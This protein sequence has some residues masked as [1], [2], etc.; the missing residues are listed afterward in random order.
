VRTFWKRGPRPL[1]N[2]ELFDERA[3]RMSKLLRFNAPREVLG[4]EARLMV[5][6][7]DGGRVRHIWFEICALI[8]RH[9]MYYVVV[10]ISRLLCRFDLYHWGEH[11][12][13][14]A[15]CIWCERGA[16]PDNSY[17]PE[18]EMTRADL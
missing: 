8:V 5:W 12:V 15:G 18:E 6:A 4:E 9:W 10:P 13:S 2:T 16:V 1:I 11:D 17:I 7:A 14:G 3:A